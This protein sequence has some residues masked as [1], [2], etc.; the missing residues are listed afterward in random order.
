MTSGDWSLVRDQ[1]PDLQMRPIYNTI[2][3][4]QAFVQMRSYNSSSAES[5]I[6]SCHFFNN[7]V[8]AVTRGSSYLGTQTIRA[9]VAANLSAP[10]RAR[11]YIQAGFLQGL[12]GVERRG[13]HSKVEL[14]QATP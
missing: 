1:S 3:G 11:A 13:R 9:A 4:E 10:S 8:R 7:H 5:Y 6:Y 14:T 12:V 2:F